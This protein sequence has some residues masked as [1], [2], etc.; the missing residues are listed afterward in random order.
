MLEAG[1]DGVAD[2]PR[3]LP[4]VVESPHSTGGGQMKRLLV[5]TVLVGLAA[6]ADQPT[7][8][9]AAM[10]DLIAQ[11]DRVGNGFPQG[12]HDYKLNIIGV[13]KN[14][15]AEM[16]NN[17]GRRIF[18]QLFS[19]K[20]KGWGGNK[21]LDDIT[22]STFDKTN[23]ILLTP[24]DYGVLDANATDRDGAL[25]RL[26]DPATTTYTIYARAHG[27]PGG[28]TV[29]RTCG[30]DEG[31]VVDDNGDIWCSIDPL[32]VTRMK[33]K[34]QTAEV[35]EVLTTIKIQE[36]AFVGA[37][38]DDLAL[39]TC[40]AGEDIGPGGDGEYQVLIFSSCF[41][42]YFWNYDNNGLRVLELRFYSGS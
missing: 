14:K 38:D 22:W 26:P 6:C 19:D 3:I 33:G 23:L 41:E 34:Q 21:V 2:L 35:T 1:I 24:G 13:P 9:D 42:Q 37:D 11:Q 7:A 32:E 25:F 17:N 4:N 10:P 29:M 12:S 8:P 31:L 5:L 27:K 18:V 39:Q 36:S 15:T 28:S 40:L 16:D 30:F 20:N